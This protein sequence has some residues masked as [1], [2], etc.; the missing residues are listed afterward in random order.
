MWS[1]GEWGVGSGVISGAVM[2]WGATAILSLHKGKNTNNISGL[3]DNYPK[4]ILLV[5]KKV[6]PGIIFKKDLFSSQKQRGKT[7]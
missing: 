6:A 1:G 7:L 3:K 5:Y 4:I 2:S